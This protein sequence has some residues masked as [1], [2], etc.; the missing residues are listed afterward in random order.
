M[1]QC[2][3]SD[4]SFYHCV[5]NSKAVRN[6]FVKFAPISEQWEKCRETVNHFIPNKIIVQSMQS[7]SK[8]QNSMNLGNNRWRRRNV[9]S[10]ICPTDT[11]FTCGP[12]SVWS[13]NK[14]SFIVAAINLLYEYMSW[15]NIMWS[16]HVIL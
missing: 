1:L 6:T 5:W 11:N 13:F 16:S 12:C 14:Y 4:S 3:K 15:W 9:F 7:V 2:P 10:S 8:K